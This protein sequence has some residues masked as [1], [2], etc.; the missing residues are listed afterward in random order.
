MKHNR[1]V[2]DAEGNEI[3]IVDMKGVSGSPV[4]RLL[5]HDQGIWAP[6]KS[7]KVVGVQ[8]SFKANSFIRAKQ[9]SLVEKIVSTL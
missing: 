9:W 8:G 2:R 6:E 4:W 5:K 3:N 7:L 1:R